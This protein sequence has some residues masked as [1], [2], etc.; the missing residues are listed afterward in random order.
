MR[1]LLLMHEGEQAGGASGSRVAAGL[2]WAGLGV[3]A[4]RPPPR[5]PPTPP[6]CLGRTRGSAEWYGPAR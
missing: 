4:C 6:A 5:P 2:S 3:R 1:Q